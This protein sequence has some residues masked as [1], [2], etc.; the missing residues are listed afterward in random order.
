MIDKKDILILNE[1]KADA[2][3]SIRAIAAKLGM[4]PSTV[5]Q[6]IRRLKAERAIEKFTVKVSDAAV[7]EEFIAFM[8]V[9]V[10]PGQKIEGSTLGKPCIKEVFGITG[11]HD[12]LLK[13]KFR[14][15]GEFNSFVLEFRKEPFVRSTLTLVATVKIKEDI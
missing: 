11:S 15:I 5:H 14:D 12:V 10:R 13:M 7:G 2:S 3:A 6:R 4:R 8:L 9:K 1:L